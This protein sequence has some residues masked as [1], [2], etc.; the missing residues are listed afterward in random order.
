MPIDNGNSGGIVT[1]IFEA[2]QAVEQDR[3]RFGAANIT[4]NSAHIW[5]C[6]GGCPQP[7]ESHRVSRLAQDRH[8]VVAAG[9]PTALFRKKAPAR[10]G[11][12][13]TLGLPGGADAE[14]LSRGTGKPIQTGILGGD[15]YREY[16]GAAPG[17]NATNA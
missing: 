11:A 2:T 12:S 15:F 10:G 14:L 1:A 8:I 13:T 16:A 9:V 6:S 5:E 17:H 4:D 7:Q 3:R